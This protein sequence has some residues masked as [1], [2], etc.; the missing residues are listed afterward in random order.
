MQEAFADLMQSLEKSKLLIINHRV[1]K[2]LDPEEFS[3]LSLRC[4]HFY[5]GTRT[6]PQSWEFRESIVG[7][8]SSG[9]KGYASAR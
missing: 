8:I 6:S 4:S 2:S 7:G 3:C 5:A 1:N 9:A